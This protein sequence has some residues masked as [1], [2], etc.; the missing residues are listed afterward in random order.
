MEKTKKILCIAFSLLLCLSFV[1]SFVDTNDLPATSDFNHD[2]IYTHIDKMCEDY[3][4][5]VRKE[6][7][8]ASKEGE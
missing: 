8:M 7:E 6:I 4:N 5:M 2:N 3:K 1:L